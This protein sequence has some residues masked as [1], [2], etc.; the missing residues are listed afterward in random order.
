MQLLIIWLG[1]LSH[2]ALAQQEIS[3]KLTSSG[4]LP[5]LVITCIANL[6]I[7]ITCFLGRKL[8]VDV[9][10][11]DVVGTGPKLED[12]NGFG[13]LSTCKGEYQNASVVLL[14]NRTPNSSMRHFMKYI[15]KTHNLYSIILQ[16]IRL[17]SAVV[18]VETCECSE[19]GVTTSSSDSKITCNCIVFWTVEDITIIL[20]HRMP[21]I[22]KRLSDSLCLLPSLQCLKNG[23]HGC[24]EGLLHVEGQRLREGDS[25]VECPA[26]VCETL[27]IFLDFFGTSHLLPDC[28][29]IPT[30][31]ADS[32]EW[33]KLLIR[34]L[35]YEDP[36][37]R[38]VDRVVVT[39]S[40][41]LQNY[42]DQ[43]GGC[44]AIERYKGITVVFPRFAE[45]VINVVLTGCL[46]VDGFS[47]AL[48]ARRAVRE[49]LLDT[50][51][52][53]FSANMFLVQALVKSNGDYTH[54]C[55]VLTFTSSVL[56]MRTLSLI[57]GSVNLFCS[58]TWALLVAFVGGHHQWYDIH[59][60]PLSKNRVA[61][62]MAA[63][64]IALLMDCLDWFFLSKRLRGTGRIGDK[65]KHLFWAAT[66]LEIVYIVLG[67]A[68]GATLG[69]KGFGSWLYGAL[70]GLVWVKW[71]IGSVLLDE[72]L[73]AFDNR[74]QRTQR[75]IQPYLYGRGSRYRFESGILV[76]S[77]AF[78]LNAVL[79][80][81]RA[82]WTYSPS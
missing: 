54:V 5:D 79:A 12:T 76:Y 31:P 22:L 14:S 80:G 55:Q 4:T 72:F 15:Y 60:M 42:M 46:R 6:S 69:I 13:V 56:S 39:A 61:V 9:S 73:E 36:E 29:C 81:V 66:V 78:F 77:S 49:Y 45:L 19:H 28:I 34:S 57:V 71:G 74:Q 62:L 51:G 37:V 33:T 10:A 64:N 44:S 50:K 8:D 24:N 38:S 53:A 75:K 70:Q 65:M 17:E 67:V 18:T 11:R 58:I 43:K 52:T 26:A 20:A 82:N 35:R 3:E 63:I 59:S 27:D 25:M 7:F 32:D 1:W 21:G 40:D 2:V 68:I 47:S 41:A 23:C 30:H 16:C 48:V